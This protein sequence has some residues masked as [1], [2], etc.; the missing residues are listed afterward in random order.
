MSPSTS[1]F[2]LSPVR[3]T[4]YCSNSS[5]CDFWYF[6]TF[7]WIILPSSSGFSGVKEIAWQQHRVGYECAER[8]ECTQAN[9]GGNAIHWAGSW[10]KYAT[11]RGTVEW[12][13]SRRA[14]GGHCHPPRRPQG[15]DTTSC[16]QE[17]STTRQ[18]EPQI[19]RNI[20]RWY[21]DMQARCWSIQNLAVAGLASRPTFLT[22]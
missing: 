7:Q 21:F 4:E 20:L 6:P 10:C 2:Q 9:G 17:P 11:P 8:S 12:G 19:S 18:W 15:Y 14:S 5:H 13:A 22:L 16:R 3:T 1:T